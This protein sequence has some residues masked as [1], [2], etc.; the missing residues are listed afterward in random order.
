MFPPAPP[1]QARKLMFE[2]REVSI[3]NQ[4]YLTSGNGGDFAIVSRKELEKLHAIKTLFSEIAKG[5]ASA[6]QEGWL[7]ADN[8]E[9]RLGI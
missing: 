5:E 4:V 8:V 1:Y 6:R 9:A 2:Q 3:G 7:S